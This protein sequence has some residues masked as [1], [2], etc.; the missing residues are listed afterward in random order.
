MDALLQT[1]ADYEEKTRIKVCPLYRRM[2][3]CGE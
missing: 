2:L 3:L 1:A